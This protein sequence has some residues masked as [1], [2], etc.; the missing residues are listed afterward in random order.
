MNRDPRTF[1]LVAGGAEVLGDGILAV[2]ADGHVV[3]AQMAPWQYDYT[4]TNPGGSQA[5]NLKRTFRRTACLT[6]RIL[7]NMGVS[8][9]T[10]LV[11]RF[12]KPPASAVAWLDSFYLDKPQEFD[13][14]YRY[15]SW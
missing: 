4:A 12:A 3:L 9:A 10:P 2:A 15:Y 1:D 6:N 8:A 5:Y 7:G 14:P 13:D 11:E